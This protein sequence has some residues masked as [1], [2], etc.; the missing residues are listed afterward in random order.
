MLHSLCSPSRQS[1]EMIYFLIP[2][3]V[4]RTHGVYHMRSIYHK[5]RKGFIS[6]AALP[7]TKA[8][9][10]KKGRLCSQSPPYTPKAYLG[11]YFICRKK[12]SLFAKAKNTPSH[13]RGISLSLKRGIDSSPELVFSLLHY[14]LLPITCQIP[15]FLVKSEE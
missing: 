12:I 15:D 7:P 11:V 5:S 1:R 8:G 2:R 13:W 6:L 10:E 3:R 4:Y 14:S 9:G